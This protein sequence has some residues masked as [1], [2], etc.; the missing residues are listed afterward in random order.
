MPKIKENSIFFKAFS[1]LP[2]SLSEEIFSLAEGRENGIFDLCEIFVR[3]EGKN[4]VNFSGE[5]IELKG[6]ITKND[7]DFMVKGL[8]Q[9]SLYAHR[10]SIG[11]GYISLPHGVRVGLCGRA[12]YDGERLIGI[13]DLS[14]FLFRFPSRGCD[15]GDELLSVFSSLPCRGMLIYSPPGMGKTTALSFLARSLGQKS[16][17][18]RIALIDTRC[19]FDGTSF[20]GT[21]VDHL[22]GYSR[23]LGIE[24]ATRTL[25]SDIIMIDELSGGDFSE[26]KALLHSGVIF[27]ATCHASSFEDLL[28][29]KRSAELIKLA[30]FD[31]FVGISR[32]GKKYTLKV[33]RI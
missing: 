10:D 15:F 5:R 11:Q 20:V 25:S 31:L 28:L 14:S 23:P 21:S 6:K 18:P 33:K 32:V 16:P 9:N 2:S 22:Q 13:T 4:E 30:V 17:P 26:I 12:K 27:I 19:E 29:S 8:T 7:V 1:L 3:R 24:I